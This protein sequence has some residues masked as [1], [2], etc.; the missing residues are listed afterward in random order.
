VSRVSIALK[1]FSRSQSVVYDG[2][3]LS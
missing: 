2:W 1:R 3:K